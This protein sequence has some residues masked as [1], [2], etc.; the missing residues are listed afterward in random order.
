MLFWK[1]FGSIPIILAVNFANEIIMSHTTIDSQ[2]P[3][4]NIKLTKI[5]LFY[6]NKYREMIWRPPSLSELTPM[7]FY[8]GLTHLRSETSISSWA[9]NGYKLITFIFKEM[10]KYHN[11]SI[12]LRPLSKRIVSY[13]TIHALQL[14]SKLTHFSL[15]SSK[16]LS[17]GVPRYK[18]YKT[19]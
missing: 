17:A 9:Y 5:I 19:S 18:Y 10:G 8:R 6:L 3:L 2:Y 15:N 16:N 11:I 14:F 7:I 4:N 12:K 1:I 13:V